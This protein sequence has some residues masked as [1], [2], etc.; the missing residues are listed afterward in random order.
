MQAKMHGGMN[1]G[2]EAERGPKLLSLS[3]QVFVYVYVERW[4]TSQSMADAKQGLS[5][6]T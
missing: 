5:E 2:E 1:T 3:V 6:K 4:N